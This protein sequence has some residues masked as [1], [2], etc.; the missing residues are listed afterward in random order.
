M[1]TISA[2]EAKTHFGRLLDQVA[3]GQEIVI[4]RYD[5]PVA[6]I[7]PEGQ[8]DS[9]AVATAAGG[10]VALQQRI[11]KRAGGKALLTM[12]RPACAWQRASRTKSSRLQ[13]SR[14]RLWT[15]A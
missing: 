15:A 10:L 11:A 14:T 1:A 2:F 3:S 13:V 5:R 4:T 9:R 7:V 12:T 6:R 8:R